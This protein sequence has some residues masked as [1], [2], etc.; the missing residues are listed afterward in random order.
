MVFF[1]ML[2]KDVQIT[3][4]NAELRAQKVR[5]RVRKWQ[6]ANP[7]KR[8]AQNLKWREANVDKAREA[9]R[10]S[11]ARRRLVKGDEIRKYQRE[12]NREWRKANPEKAKE[13]G[14]RNYQ[15]NREQRRAYGRIQYERDKEVV[16]ARSER[17]RLENKDKCNARGR[18]R[19]AD[20]PERAHEYDRL[21]NRKRRLEQPE[22][23]REA[24]RKWA[25]N[26]PDKLKHKGRVRRAREAGAMGACTIEQLKA[27]VAFFGNCCAYCEGLFEEVDHTIA[28][29]RGG[30]N[31][32]ANLR[33]ACKLC[34][35][36]KHAHS[37]RKWKVR[38]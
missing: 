4:A 26:N 18:K 14:R 17:W 16:K 29:S 8:R 33:P 3:V 38:I 37:W 15:N 23:L 1:N 5:D 34:N 7:E 19:R 30:S 22:V 12:W 24:F 13:R 32:P 27:R 28:L 36:R 2:P 6:K 31:W 25:L 11:E 20:N 35:V 10:L 21:V 9:S